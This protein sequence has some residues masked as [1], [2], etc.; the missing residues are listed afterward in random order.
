MSTHD[1]DTHALTVD[2]IKRDDF[3]GLK[4]FVDTHGTACVTIPLFDGTYIHRMGSYPMTLSLLHLG[5]NPDIT[6][7]AGETPY[8]LAS[9]LRKKGSVDALGQHGYF[10]LP[11]A[12]ISSIDNLLS[13]ALDSNLVFNDTQQVVDKGIYY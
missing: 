6:D 5:V 4:A 9:R 3:R 1:H 10:P 8:A 2:I 12:D 13:G 11:V 7:D